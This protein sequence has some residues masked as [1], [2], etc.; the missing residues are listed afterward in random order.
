MVSGGQQLRARTHRAVRFGSQRRARHSPETIT[1]QQSIEA[2]S[3]CL[4]ATV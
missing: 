4:G 2:T 3:T 1:K